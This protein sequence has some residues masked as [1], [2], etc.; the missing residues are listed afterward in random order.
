MLSLACTLLLAAC[1]PIAPTA[2]FERVSDYDARHSRGGAQ[3]YDLSPHER[4][5]CEKKAAA[6]D[7]VAAKALL[8]YYEMVVVD[9]K[10]YQYW[11]GVVERLQKARAQQSKP[12]SK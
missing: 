6:G 4:L 3:A 7:I 2:T 8:E 1:N 5:I 11:L 9:K 10:Q 12:R